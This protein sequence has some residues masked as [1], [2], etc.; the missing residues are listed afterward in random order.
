MFTRAVGRQEVRRPIQGNDVPKVGSTKPK[1]RFRGATLY[2]LST[3]EDLG[4]LKLLTVTWIDR[5]LAPTLRSASPP[6]SKLGLVLTFAPELHANDSGRRRTSRRTNFSTQNS[7]SQNDFSAQNNCSQN[8]LSQNNFLTQN[9]ISQKG[10]STPVVR[11]KGS[12]A[13]HRYPAAIGFG[14]PI[15]PLLLI[16]DEVFT[17]DHTVKVRTLARSGTSDADGILLAARNAASPGY[18]RYPY[19]RRFRTTL[20]V[21]L[22]TALTAPQRPCTPALSNT[23]T[24]IAKMRPGC[25]VVRGSIV[26]V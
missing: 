22:V 13:R 3:A 14:L 16:P 11:R 12:V 8:N 23:N 26:F 19:R 1:A 24:R 10:F 9:N 21:A 20:C 18:C 2:H 6:E 4:A 15:R 25:P 5:A 7:F 17:G